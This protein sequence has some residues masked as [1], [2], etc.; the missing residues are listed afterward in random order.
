MNNNTKSQSIM[1]GILKIIA[2]IGLFI[3][4]QLPMAILTIPQKNLKPVNNILP[5]IVI[6]LTVVAFLIIYF[7]YKKAQKFDTVAFNKRTWVYILGG[8]VAFLIINYLTLLLV[9]ST[10]NSNVEALSSIAKNYLLYFLIF[11]VFLSPVFEE[12]L[13]R[14]IFMN[15]FFYRYKYLNIILSGLVFGY[16][17]APDVSIKTFGYLISKVL[18]GIVL[19]VIYRNTKN[20]KANIAVHMLN[21]LSAFFIKI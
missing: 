4:E 8:V 7:T 17:H 16:I 3:I 5:Y 12:L 1:S 19:A 9:P 21:N 11:A 6:A 2:F 18:L 14:G 20:I 15:W 13:F 10:D